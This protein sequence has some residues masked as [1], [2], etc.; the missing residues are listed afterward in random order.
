MDENIKEC[1]DELQEASKYISELEGK[2]KNVL[3]IIEERSI[4]DTPEDIYHKIEWE[5]E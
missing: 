3:M 1:L 2:I 5:L 4:F